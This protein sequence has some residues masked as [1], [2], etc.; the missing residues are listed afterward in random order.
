RDLAVD[1]VVGEPVDVHR[2]ERRAEAVLESAHLRDAHVDR[3]L[4]TF[5]PARDAG[6][7]ARELTLRAAARGLA[8]ALADASAQAADRVSCAFG[9]LHLMLFHSAGSLVS[10]GS[11]SACSRFAAGFSGA[12]LVS[13]TL[14]RCATF[15]SWPRSVT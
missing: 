5:E 9:R 14:R 10:S 8:L 6:A 2:D 13:S 11:L 1:G 3:R 15:R 4:P 12:A 7:G